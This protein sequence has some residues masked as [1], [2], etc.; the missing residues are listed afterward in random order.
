MRNLAPLSDLPTLFL[1][2]CF[3]K[4][5]I[6]VKA[7]WIQ[8]IRIQKLVFTFLNIT[9]PWHLFTAAPMT[10]HVASTRRLLHTLKQRTDSFKFPSTLAV[11][12]CTKRQVSRCLRDTVEDWRWQQQQQQQQQHVDRLWQA[13][14]T[15]E[16]EWLWDMLALALESPTLYLGRRKEIVLKCNLL[17]N[18]QNYS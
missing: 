10:H 2:L 4:Q 17:V 8:L 1:A 14:R 5:Q 3:R 12:S 16:D 7:L 9:E 11:P 15:S 13:F 18:V 6:Y